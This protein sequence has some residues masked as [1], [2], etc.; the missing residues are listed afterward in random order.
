MCNNLHAGT[1][2]SPTFL[3]TTTSANCRVKH[4]NRWQGVE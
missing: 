4:E 3:S 2:T 1:D